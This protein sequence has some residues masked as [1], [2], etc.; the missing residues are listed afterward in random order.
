M[1]SSVINILLTSFP[2][3]SLPKTLS[4]Q[5]PASSNVSDLT[6]TLSDH[7]PPN[8]CH[9][10][11]LT[12]TNNKQLLSSSSTPLKS[13]LSNSN[14]GFIPL[15]LSVPCCGGKGGFGSQLRAAGG[16]MSSR[17]K[18]RAGENNGSNRNLDGRRIRT[19]AEAKALAEYMVTKPGMEKKAR[20]E[21]KKRLEAVVESYE[22]KEEDIRAGKGRVEGKWVESRDE[23]VAKVREAVRSALRR[24]VWTDN[25]K[26]LMDSEEENDSEIDETSDDADADATATGESSEEAERS[27]SPATS[28]DE[29]SAIKKFHWDEFNDYDSEEDSEG[30][31]GD[32]KEQGHEE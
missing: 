3:L 20:E 7:L 23:G 13:L 32:E 6:S 1:E 8:L 22:K 9:R 30:G 26:N 12:T 19:I 4:L 10:L 14:D 5:L 31:S 29:S 27:E 16:R 25:L 24:G 28:P 21:R 11:I 15:R 2:G 17:R 18:G